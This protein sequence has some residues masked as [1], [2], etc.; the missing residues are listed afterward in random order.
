MASPCLS[1]H[2]SPCP[3]PIIPEL[4]QLLAAAQSCNQR[5]V[6]AFET[7]PQRQPAGIAEA[8][9]TSRQPPLETCNWEGW[10]GERRKLGRMKGWEGAGSAGAWAQR[11]GEG[12]G[13]RNMEGAFKYLMQPFSPSVKGSRH[14]Q[15]LCMGMDGNVCVCQHI[16]PNVVCWGGERQHQGL[17]L[18]VGPGRAF[19]RQRDRC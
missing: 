14:G 7:A 6:K 11:L 16:G 18:L 8:A 15:H 9:G 5:A 1:P 2:P 12:G 17:V 3:D 19:P 4:Q 10:E 13:K